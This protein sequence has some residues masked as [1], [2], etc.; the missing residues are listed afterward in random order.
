MI[1]FNLNWMYFD[2]QACKHFVHALRL[3]LPLCMSLLLASSATNHLVISPSPSSS[4]GGGIKWFFGAGLGISVCV[5]ATIGVLHKS[6]D[7]E[8]LAK[9]CPNTVSMIKRRKVFSRRVVLT[10]R[11]AA[12]VTM[13]PLAQDMDS[14]KYLGI[15]V[16]I[17]A[18]LIIEET[19][20]R[21]EGV[22]VGTRWKR[23]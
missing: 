11:Y 19:V 7:E 12:G 13:V 6:L 22:G 4:S 8:I 17:T 10:T 14:I 2:S 20:A 16:A 1:A 15:Y 9:R 5:M 23:V 21:I 18:F 3:H